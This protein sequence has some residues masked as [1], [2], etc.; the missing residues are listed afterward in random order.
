MLSFILKRI[1]WS[2]PTLLIVFGLL[3]YLYNLLPGDPVEAAYVL[4]PLK[5]THEDTIVYKQQ[6]EIYKKE[7]GLDKPTF[8][9][10]MGKNHELVWYGADNQ[11]FNKITKILQGDFGRSY[12]SKQLVTKDLSIAIKWTLIFNL[13]SII[14]IFVLGVWIGLKAALYHQT[15]LDSRIMKWSFFLDALPNFWLASLLVLFF[16]RDD[17][18]MGFMPSVGVG[19]TPYDASFAAK[20]WIAI[21][22]L[23]LPLICVVLTSVSIIIRQM[24]SAALTVMQ[25]D[26]VRTAKAKG[27]NEQLLMQKHIFPNAFF[28]ILT[29]LATSFP[30][31]IVGQIMIEN[32]FNIPGMGKLSIEALLYKDFPILFAI[33]IIIAF[34]TVV[35]NIVADSIY[36][37]YTPK[38]L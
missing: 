25:Q 36:R 13:L 10:G 5:G 34:L 24:R 11:Y 18:N 16:I 28:P 35:S 32:I 17:F 20:I 23:I 7:L 6:Y 29:V 33:L 30:Q 15:K 14:I 1:T 9:F 22:H 2:I 8:F 3:F 37:Y 26:Y 19:D 27:L 12:R 38:L 4:P 21:P 31:L